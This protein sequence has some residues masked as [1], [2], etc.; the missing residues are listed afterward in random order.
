MNAYI[1]SNTY[2]FKL[3][4][5]LLETVEIVIPASFLVSCLLSCSSETNTERLL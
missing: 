5:S 1:L 2:L 4:F 3:S